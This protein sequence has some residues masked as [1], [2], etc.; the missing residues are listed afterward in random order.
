MKPFFTKDP[1]LLAHRGMPEEYPENTLISF[2]NAVKLGV[3]VIETDTSLRTMNLSSRMMQRFLESRM[4]KERLRI[5]P[6]RS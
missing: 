5:I 1:R 3:D 2:Q 4:G 6:S